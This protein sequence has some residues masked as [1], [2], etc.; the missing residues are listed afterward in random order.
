MATV[1]ETYRLIQNEGK[2]EFPAAAKSRLSAAISSGAIISRTVTPVVDP[3]EITAG[4]TKMDVTIVWR[5]TEDR[6][7]FINDNVADSTF[8]A[9]L[10]SSGTTFNNRTII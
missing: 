1:T 6:Q 2:T 9:Y 7:N 10:A 5:S 3:S 4:K 8:A